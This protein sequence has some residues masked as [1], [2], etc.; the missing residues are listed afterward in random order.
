MRYLYAVWSAQISQGLM[1]RSHSSCDSSGV[2]TMGISNDSQIKRGPSAG[3]CK[4]RQKIKGREGKLKK[5]A[6]ENRISL[7]RLYNH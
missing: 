4:Y 7:I 2:V 1:C 6:K 5:K 3:G